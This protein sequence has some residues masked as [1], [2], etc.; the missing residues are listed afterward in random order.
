MKTNFYVIAIDGKAASGKSSTAKLLAEKLN[1]LN[2]STGEHYR[3]ISYVLAKHNISPKS[4]SEIDMFLKKISLSPKI[5]H[6]KEE[7][8]INGETFSEE[9]LRSEEVNNCVSVFAKNEHIRNVLRKYQR[10]LKDLALKNNFTGL[11][12]EGRDMTSVV[13][14]DADY[15]YFLKADI[16]NRISRR[17]NEN[18]VD[19]IRCRDKEDSKHIAIDESVT[20]IDTSAN[21]LENVVEIILQK[22]NN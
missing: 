16:S 1:L 17:A 11:V 21:S 8:S 19:C 22:L 2:V 9:I 3:A 15:K 13:F 18:E 4:Q 7:I 14:N 6:N 10:S 12:V 5:V 20:I